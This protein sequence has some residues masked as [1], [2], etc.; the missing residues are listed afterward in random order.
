MLV[1]TH[2]YLEGIVALGIGFIFPGFILPTTSLV[3]CRII[4]HYKPPGSKYFSLQ[5]LL[6]V[7]VLSHFRRFMTLQPC[8]LLPTSLLCPWDF[9]GKNTGVGLPVPSPK[10]L[11]DPGLNLS[12]LCFPQLLLEDP[13]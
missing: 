11:P 12:L 1:S 10:D 9:P 3:S 2:G 5:L 4:L 8:G 7:C 13:K 6:H